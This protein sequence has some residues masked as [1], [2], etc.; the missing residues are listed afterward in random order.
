MTGTQHLLKWFVTPFYNKFEVALFMFKYLEV[1]LINYSL[2]HLWVYRV[3]GM[4][5]F[6]CG[7]P[8]VHISEAKHHEFWWPTGHHQHHLSIHCPSVRQPGIPTFTAA[9]SAQ[10]SRWFELSL[11]DFPTDGTDK[12]HPASP[13]FCMPNTIRFLPLLCSSDAEKPNWH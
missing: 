2:E 1:F 10:V 5:V 6:A 3:S 7:H 8:A 13:L 4:E 12:Q 9:S 11:S